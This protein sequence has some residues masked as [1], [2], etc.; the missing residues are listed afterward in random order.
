MPTKSQLRIAF[1]TNIWISFSIGKK[2]DRLKS[3]FLSEKLTI[4]I[5]PEIVEEYIRVAQ[6]N[7]L[8]KYISTQRLIDTI[9]LIEEFTISKQV[10]SKVHLSRDPNDDFLLAFS[11]ENELDYLI[12]GDK[13]LLVLNEISSTKIISFNEFIEMDI[14]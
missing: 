12:T 7:K 4:I 8:A 2:L 5:C 3:V 6:S 9:A 13:D 14:L 1:D 10:K 11:I